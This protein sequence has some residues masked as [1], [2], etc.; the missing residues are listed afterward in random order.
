VATKTAITVSAAAAMSRTN[1]P[2]VNRPSDGSSDVSAGDS[3]SAVK[4]SPLGHAGSFCDWAAV[5]GDL[6]HLA[7]CQTLQI[8][9]QRGVADAGSI[10]LTV[11]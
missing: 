2:S 9:A 7:H 8:L 5:E 6:L 11:G 3:S 10:V 4:I 1:N